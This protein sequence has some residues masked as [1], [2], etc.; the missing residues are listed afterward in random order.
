MGAFDGA[1]DTLRGDQVSSGF[2]GEHTSTIDWCE[3]NYAHTPYIAET[4][5]TLTNLPSILLGLYGFYAV[6]KNGLPTRFAFCYLGL[7]LIGIGSFGFHMSLRWEWQLM[8]ELP[9]IY[10]V[11]YAAFL[12][13]ETSPGLKLR[14]GVL[15]PGI[16]VL[17]DVFVTTSYIYLPNPVYH[18]IAFAIILITT[19]ARTAYLAFKLPPNHPSKVKIGKTMAWGV[20]TFA[21]GF[22]IWNVD[23]LFC[24]QLRMIREHVGPLGVFVEVHNPMFRKWVSSSAAN[25]TSLTPFRRCSSIPST[26]FVPSR[27]H[28][29]LLPPR[30]I[31]FRP[32]V[33]FCLDRECPP[34]ADKPFAAGHAYWH[35]MTG[36]GSFLIFTASILLHLC[37]KVS[38]DAYTFDEKAFFPVV[39]PLHSID[40]KKV[41]E[42]GHSR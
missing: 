33:Y 28:F 11:S 2:W 12:I 39:Y 15:G 24:P 22:A 3:N 26:S 5:N 8:D 36:Y 29:A 34:T 17:W 14:Y 10:V 38:P 21:V 20:V 6:V 18:Q 35:L 19:T 1:F 4:V 31:L 40:R 25:F 9:M 32:S 42:N 23:N 7:S 37:I 30:F 16:M 41:K 13:L 27:P